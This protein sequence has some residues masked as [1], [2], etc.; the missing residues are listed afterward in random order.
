MV[1]VGSS[2]VAGNL[3]AENLPVFLAGGLSG[4]IG[5]AILLPVLFLHEG[6][7]PAAGRG[8]AAAGRMRLLGRRQTPPQ[9]LRRAAGAAGWQENA[10]VDL[11][12][13]SSRCLSHAE[14]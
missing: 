7:L 11:R 13:G 12:R 5:A 10:L 6:G 3:M 2:V 8:G 4:A 1:L 9:T 14:G